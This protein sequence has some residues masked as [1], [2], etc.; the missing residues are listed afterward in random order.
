MNLNLKTNR[1]QGVA[2]VLA[3]VVMAVLTVVL[4]VMAVQVVSQRQMVRQ[5]HKQ[6]QADWLARAGVELAAARL[7]QNPGG[8]NEVR[9]ELVPDAIL[10]VHVEKTD[11]DEY[12]VTAD[13]T[14]S[15]EEGSPVERTAS[16][17]FRRIERDGV[18]HLEALGNTKDPN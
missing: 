9:N 15:A 12:L 1:R 10:R 17:R 8:F 13:A 4:S 14:V 11:G 5:R 16:A 6:L 18:V 3:M 2:L 7:L